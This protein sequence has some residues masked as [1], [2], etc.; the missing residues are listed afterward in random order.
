MSWP[1]YFTWLG[2]HPWIPIAL[3]AVVAITGLEWRAEFRRRAADR[4][5]W[6]ACKLCDAGK[7]E[8]TNVLRF[9]LFAAVFGCLVGAAAV[10]SA[11][12]YGF[13]WF[14]D[15]SA[16]TKDSTG[17]EV[18]IREH[19]AGQSATV[20]AASVL[21]VIACVFLARSRNILRCTSCG[22]AVDRA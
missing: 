20:A 1:D 22:A 14:E 16:I 11:L 12:I 13:H 8:P 10:G 2:D 4:E 18:V 7:M 6:S 3:V 9:G 19:R 5:R 17:F 21:V 15:V